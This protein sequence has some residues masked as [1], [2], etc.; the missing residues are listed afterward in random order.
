MGVVCQWVTLYELVY[1][2]HSKNVLST[3]NL[4]CTFLKDLSNKERNTLFDISKIFNEFAS[5]SGLKRNN[6]LITQNQHMKQQLK[7]IIFCHRCTCNYYT[8]IIENKKNDML[9]KHTT[10]QGVNIVFNSY[11]LQSLKFQRMSVSM[12]MFCFYVF[13]TAYNLYQIT[14]YH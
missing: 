4:I 10:T 11:V 5:T 12:F 7:C 1:K 9:K 6:H 2:Y 13:R 8:L 14:Q 3:F